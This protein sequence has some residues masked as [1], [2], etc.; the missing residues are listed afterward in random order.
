ML[1]IGYVMLGFF[2]KIFISLVFTVLVEIDLKKI[3][4]LLDF[5]SFIYLYFTFCDRLYSD[6]NIV[7]S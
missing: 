7:F 2:N 5:V 1:N 6:V 3:L 4:Y